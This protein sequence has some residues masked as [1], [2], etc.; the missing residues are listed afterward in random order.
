MASPSTDP[1]R[2]PAVR[3]FTALGVVLLALGGFV[4]NDSV[5]YVGVSDRGGVGLAIIL[6]SAGL[7]SLVVAAVTLGTRLGLVEHEQA[8]RAAGD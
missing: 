1:Y 2:S 8:R 7:L 3:G 6:M 4:L 5:S